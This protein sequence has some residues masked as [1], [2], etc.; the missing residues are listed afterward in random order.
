MW[1]LQTDYTSSY[2]VDVTAPGLRAVLPANLD[3][4]GP[5]WPIGRI[6]TDG[7]DVK[8]TF[9]VRDALLSEAPTGASLVSVIATRASPVQ[10][11]PIRRA[12]GKYVDW[13]RGGAPAQDRRRQ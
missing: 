11:V 3:R 8:L 2:P 7:G 10:V 13:Y 12:C 5:R 4:P 9:R 1:D 6:A